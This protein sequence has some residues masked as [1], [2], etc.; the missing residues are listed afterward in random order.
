MEANKA[1]KVKVVESFKDSQSEHLVCRD[2]LVL[3]K[4][5]IENHSLIVNGNIMYPIIISETE[6]IEVGDKYYCDGIIYNEAFE[7]NLDCKDNK[8]ILALPEHFSPKQLQAIVNGKIKDGDEVF[9]ECDGVVYVTKNDILDSN[10]T[11][12]REYWIK[13][14][15]N[16]IKLFPI[17]QKEKLYNINQMA[18]YAIKFLIKSNNL[19]NMSKQYIEDYEKYF[20]D[21]IKNN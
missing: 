14:T 5:E 7:K 20:I 4:G 2:K 10:K 15:N 19:K 13:L 12:I 1:T 11:A 6:K 17:K 18:N 21:W 9:I 8:K 3:V 16:Q